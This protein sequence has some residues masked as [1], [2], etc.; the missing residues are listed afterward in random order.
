VQ[1]EPQVNEQSLRR[2][3]DESAAA[4]QAQRLGALHLGC[5]KKDICPPTLVNLGAYHAE[6]QASDDC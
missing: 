3:P 6:I 4:E 2:T 5:E 1:Q